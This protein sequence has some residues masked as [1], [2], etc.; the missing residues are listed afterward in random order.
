MSIKEIKKENMKTFVTTRTNMQKIHAVACSAW[1]PIIT[2]LTNKYAES[3]FSEKVILPKEE[4]QKMFGAATHSQIRTLNEVFPDYNEDKNIFIKNPTSDQIRDLNDAL[5]ALCPDFI[6]EMVADAGNVM[7][8][9]DLIGRGLYVPS[10]IKVI[11]H[12][13]GDSS[14]IEFVKK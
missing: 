1:K 10:Y 2:D 4:V 11:V 9:P 5:R 13:V 14:V 6:V 3:T 8:R 7:N 12:E